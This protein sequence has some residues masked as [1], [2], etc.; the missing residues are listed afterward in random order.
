MQIVE[1]HT[2]QQ[3]SSE[4]DQALRPAIQEKNG[5]TRRDAAWHAEKQFCNQTERSQGP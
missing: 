4:H 2:E 3:Q 5:Y 1:D